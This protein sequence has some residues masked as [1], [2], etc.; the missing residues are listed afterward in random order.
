MRLLG[1]G[2]ILPQV[3]GAAQILAD[4]FGIAS[5]IF[6]V[7]SWSELEREAR[8]VARRNRFDAAPEVSHVERLLAGPRPVIAASDYVR[9]LPQMIAP[10]VGGRFVVLGT[11]G[12]GRSANRADLRAF[13]EVDSPSIALAAVEAL[14]RAGDLA[15]SVLAEAVKAL[16]LDPAAPPL[17]AVRPAP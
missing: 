2:A 11:D 10:Y 8:A 4:R 12:F 6:S 16:G 14:V 5:E 3:I 9:A 1:S 13:F 15:P 17:D 7:T